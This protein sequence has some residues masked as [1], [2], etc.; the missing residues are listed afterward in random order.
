VVISGRLP[1]LNQSSFR[2]ANEL[3]VRPNWDSTFIEASSSL[4]FLTHS[5]THWVAEKIKEKE[6]YVTK[7]IRQEYC[8]KV[9]IIFFFFFLISLVEPWN[10]IRNSLVKWRKNLGIQ[11]II[12]RQGWRWRRRNLWSTDNIRMSSIDVGV[13]SN[14]RMREWSHTHTHTHT[15][16]QKKKRKLDSSIQ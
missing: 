7:I 14:Y 15:H 10:K 12:P 8:E 9:Q 3:N 6:Y 5:F 11:S 2:H 1:R 13:D 16:T 4:L